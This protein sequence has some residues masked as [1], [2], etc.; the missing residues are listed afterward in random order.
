MTNT[1]LELALATALEPD[2]TW[3]TRDCRYSVGGLWSSTISFRRFCT[4]GNACL[5]LIEAL[6]RIGWTCDIQ[7]H[8]DS[9]ECALFMNNGE[10]DYVSHDAFVGGETNRVPLAVARAA[11]KALGVYDDD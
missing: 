5:A 2:P 3:E 10:P 11:A 7:I 6:G 1:E 4:D 8:E 9:A